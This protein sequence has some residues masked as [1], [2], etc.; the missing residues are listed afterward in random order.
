MVRAYYVASCNFCGDA[1]NPS[2]GIPTLKRVEYF[3]G[4]YRETALAEGVENLQFE[5]A[6]DIRLGDKTTPG[7]TASQTRHG[8]STRGHRMASS[9]RF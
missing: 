9:L 1:D 3:N 8:L 2:D 6:F 4:A 7:A 5:Y